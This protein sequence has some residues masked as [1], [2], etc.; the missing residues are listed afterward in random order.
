[1]QVKIRHF[2]QSDI[3]DLAEIYSYQS[4]TEYTSQ[5][6]FLNSDTVREFF[7]SA[8]DYILVAELDGKVVGHINLIMSNKPREKHAASL[9][10]AVHPNS[11]GKGVGRKLLAEAINQADNW[12]N[13]LRIEL[14]VYTDN[15]AG[16]S[17]YKKFDFKVEG[18]KQSC[19]YK[20]GRFVDL[21]ILARLNM[22]I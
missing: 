12:L 15:E 21:L 2:E 7:Q 5:V 20:N 14:E 6:P 9:A 22:P 18:Q 8:T 1:M 17:L 19:S 4:V 3:A 13:L 10:I 11:H 16:L